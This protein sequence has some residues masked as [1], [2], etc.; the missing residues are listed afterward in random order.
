MD[1]WIG[2]EN[3]KKK[4]EKFPH[5]RSRRRR[6]GKKTTKEETKSFFFFIRLFGKI[7]VVGA[8][9]RLYYPDCINLCVSNQNYTVK[10]RRDVIGGIPLFRTPSVLS[11]FSQF[12]T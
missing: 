7:D 3:K 12:P 9:Q 2:G 5:G 1:V 10:K 8:G 4:E 11:S 6:R